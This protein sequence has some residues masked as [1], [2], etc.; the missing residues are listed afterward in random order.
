[1]MNLICKQNCKVCFAEPVCAL[2]AIIVKERAVY[3][4]TDKCIG[5]GTCRFACI[6]WSLDKAL[7][8][9]TVDWLKGAA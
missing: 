1:M 8:E 9:K 6:E 7:K 3:V 4:E 2:D 5:C